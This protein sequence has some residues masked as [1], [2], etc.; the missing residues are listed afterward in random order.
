M[1]EIEEIVDRHNRRT[2]LNHPSFV[3]LIGAGA[4]VTSHIPDGATVLKGLKKKYKFSHE[5]VDEYRDKLRMT[6][7][8][9]TMYAIRNHSANGAFEISDYI[10]M[11]IEKNARRRAPDNRWIIN[12][13]HEVVAGILVHKP[14]FARAAITTNFDPLLNY[15]LLQQWNTEPLL[16]RHYDEVESMKPAALQHRFPVL[17]HIHGYWQNHEVYN[18]P[19]QFAEWMSQWNA[20]LEQSWP[21]DVIV[22]GYSGQEDSIAMEWLRCCVRY[23]RTVWWCRYAPGGRLREFLSDEDIVANLANNRISTG[24]VRSQVEFIPIEGAD[25]FALQLG[26]ALSVPGAKDMKGIADVF[27]WFKP[28]EVSAFGNNAT[29]KLKTYK[30]NIAF[31]ESPDALEPKI[32]FSMAGA[33]NPANNHAGIN[34]DTVEREFRMPKRATKIRI[35]YSGSSSQKDRRFE[36]KLHSRKNAHRVLIPIFPNKQGYHDIPLSKFLNVDLKTIWRVVIAADSD[37]I[38]P[39]EKASIRIHRTELLDKT[40][41]SI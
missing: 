34:I 28:S 40:G 38:K 21:S 16:I 37:A 1:S 24:R 27:P 18:D 7:Y 14:D 19:V 17:L 32:T 15:A 35:Y 10:R 25:Q 31:R 20:A 8:Q 41:H 3:F 11:L 30:G 29:A 22:I 2:V 23:G 9:A 33:K 4:S 13:C 39:R 12:N 5:V 36:F 26:T 6:E